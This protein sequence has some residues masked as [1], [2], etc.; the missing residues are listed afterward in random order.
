MRRLSNLIGQILYA[1]GAIWTFALAFHVLIDVVGRAFNV[2][3]PG[4]VEV[5]RESI[6]CIVFLQVAY[7]VQTGG[8]LRV[9]FFVDRFGERG[10]RLL[11]MLGYLLGVLF[12][13]ILAIGAWEHAMRA[14]QFAETEGDGA[15]RMPT[16]PARFAIVLGSILSA[17]NYALLIAEEVAAARHLPRTTLAS[18]SV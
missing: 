8:M 3:I 15:F 17:V 6:I 9:D 5:A 18:G 2:S 10:S 16:W 11:T 7:C 12:F 4:T 1:T 14:W 13:G